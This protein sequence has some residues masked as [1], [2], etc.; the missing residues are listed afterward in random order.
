[1]YRK[2][3]LLTMIA[4][5][6]VCVGSM[7]GAQAAE[8]TRSITLKTYPSELFYTYIESTLSSK[9]SRPGDVVTFFVTQPLLVDTFTILDKGTR[10]TAKITSVTPA[11]GR[12]RPGSIELGDFA[13]KAIDG[14]S[15]PVE[16]SNSTIQ[17]RP[18]PIALLE[19]TSTG[20]PALRRN[21]GKPSNIDDSVRW[22]F[23]VHSAVDAQR[24][25]CD[26]VVAGVPGV[27]ARTGRRGEDAETVGA[28]QACSQGV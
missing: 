2:T 25:D 7:L 1:M 9:S 27:S 15:L 16:T 17:G 19:S 28:A 13:V 5:V 22:L 4:A 23:W 6:A 21:S 3:K 18:V 24:M 14:T 12:G 20:F 8:D 26:S 11:K 10:V